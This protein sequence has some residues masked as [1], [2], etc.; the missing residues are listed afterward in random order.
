M[1]DARERKGL[2]AISVLLAMAATLVFLWCVAQRILYPFELEWM[3]GGSLQHLVRLAEGLPLYATP[4]IEFV[5]F[6]YPPL[7]YYAALAL[8]PLLGIEL[9]TLRLV[10]LVSTI[11][12]AVLLFVL[13]RFETRRVEAATAAA[14]LYLASYL[15]S[16]AY[17][18]V[19]RLDAFFFFLALASLC[20]LRMRDDAVGWVLAALLAAAATATKQTAPAIFAPVLLWAFAKEHLA[21]A[22]GGMGSRRALVLAAVFCVATGLA[23]AAFSAGGNG[24]FFDYVFGAQAAHEIR[25]SMVPA[26]FGVD[27]FSVLPL[28]TLVAAIGLWRFA[29][30]EARVFYAAVFLGVCLACIVPRV[31]VGGAMNNL[32]PLH[33]TAILLAGVGFGAW[34]NAHTASRRFAHLAMLGLVAQFAWLGFD[35]RIALPRPGDEAAGLRFVEQLRQVEG[36]ILI[37]AHGYLARQ[38]GK[39][40]FAHQMPIDDLEDSGLAASQALRREFARAIEARRFALIVDSSSRFL[41]GYP[42]AGWLAAHYRLQGPVFRAPRT[43]VPRSGWPVSPGRVW[44]PR[45]WPDE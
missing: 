29:A 18:D 11:G 45:D 31:K 16:G 15:E 6:P 34:A 8:S 28:A 26:F 13:V 24:A 12:T 40:V 33:A 43:L 30:P 37:P 5:P 14:G 2:L 20:C 41:E 32:L 1:N 27:L 36:E 38:A 23:A 39:S 3:E 21:H 22:G 17:M 44:V 19:A 42:E 35:P 25:W 10:S 9:A 4:S 7:Y